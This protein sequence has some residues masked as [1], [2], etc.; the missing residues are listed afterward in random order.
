HILNMT[1]I[2]TLP[3]LKD[4]SDQIQILHQTGKNDYDEVNKAYAESPIQAV[5]SPFISNMDEAYAESHLMICRAGSSVSE[6]IAVGRASITVPIPNSS[7]DHQKK[8]AETLQNADAGILIEQKDLTPNLLAEK[9]I[10]LLKNS[11]KID[12]MEKKAKA[13]YQGD[14][15]SAIVDHTFQYFQF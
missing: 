7:G 11:E 5:V 14:A 15:T 12:E 13:L 9:I 2:K 10:D 6:I 8:N 3:L 4:Y 1:M